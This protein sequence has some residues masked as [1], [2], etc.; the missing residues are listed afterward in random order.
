MDWARDE[1]NF[2]SGAVSKEEVPV[3][4]TISSE[5]RAQRI[6]LASGTTSITVAF[7][8]SL[9]ST[10]YSLTTTLSNLVDPSVNYRPLTITSL[11]A[12]G[13]TVKWNDP[14]DSSNYYLNY[15]ATKFA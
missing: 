15:T 12:T 9:D 7:S 13:F 4:R 5:T 3:F 10:D 1:R 2:D 14:L 8:S 6:Q 11:S